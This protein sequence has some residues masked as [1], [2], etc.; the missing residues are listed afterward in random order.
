MLALSFCASCPRDATRRL[1]ATEVVC[2]DP[3]QQQL[4]RSS[5]TTQHSTGRLIVASLVEVL[6]AAPRGGTLRHLEEGRE[7][8]A[9]S[10]P[11]QQH[12][13]RRSS[14]SRRE[15]TA[16]SRDDERS[17]GALL[18]KLLREVHANCHLTS[19]SSNFT[20]ERAGCHHSSP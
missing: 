9:A 7:L 8:R 16:V 19:L 1:S 17:T 6:L 4:R 14:R 5:T 20:N 2:A 13:L 11:S 3:S 15:A 18:L 10:T 12:Q